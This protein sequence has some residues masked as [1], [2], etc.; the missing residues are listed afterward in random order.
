MFVF[1]VIFISNMLMN[2]IVYVYLWLYFIYI[3]YYCEYW[4]QKVMYLL[5]HE[6][7]CNML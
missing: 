1:I 5:I 6:T 4:E 3:V 2:R 7:C